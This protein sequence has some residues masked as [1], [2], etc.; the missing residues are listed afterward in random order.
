MVISSAINGWSP[1]KKSPISNTK[2]TADARA[3]YLAFI[4]TPSPAVFKDYGAI[5]LP[6]ISS[7][8][9]GNTLDSFP[10]S[11][12]VLRKVGSYLDSLDATP[13]SRTVAATE[14]FT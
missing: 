13:S 2:P 3:K 5:R 6:F 9:Q 12:Q 14:I 11:A 10:K 7:S 1:A 8:K 4:D